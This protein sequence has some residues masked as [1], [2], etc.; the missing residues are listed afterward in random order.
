MNNVILIGRIVR[1]P[2]LKEGKNSAYLMNTLAI[3]NDFPDKDGVYGTTFIPFTC[4]GSAAKVL[5]NNCVKGQSV[6]LKA[7]LQP[8]TIEHEDGSKTYD[9]QVIINSIELCEKARQDANY[10]INQTE[11]DDISGDDL[12]F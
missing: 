2:E 10:P 4:F 8:R 7:K 3:R 6:C 12:P 5:A 11:E 9:L 1:E